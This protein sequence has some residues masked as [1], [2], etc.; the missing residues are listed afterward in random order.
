MELCYVLQPMRISNGMCVYVVVDIMIFEFQSGSFENPIIVDEVS[1]L[2]SSMNPTLIS[3][4]DDI[5]SDNDS[6][7][8]SLSFNDLS[9]E[10]SGI[11]EVDS[12]DTV[13]IVNGMF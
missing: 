12:N 5:V 8:L 4:G 13:A 11:S 9:E 7:I 10:D 3:D 6:D 2:G 1:R